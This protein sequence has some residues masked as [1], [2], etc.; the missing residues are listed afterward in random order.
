MLSAI[1]KN[2][3]MRL[4]IDVFLNACQAPNDPNRRSKKEYRLIQ[5]SFCVG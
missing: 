1:S 4:L 3:I 2:A 5:Y